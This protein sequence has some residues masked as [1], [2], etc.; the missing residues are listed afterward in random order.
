MLLDIFIGGGG[1]NHIL[2]LFIFFAIVLTN[3][4]TQQL[5]RIPLQKPLKH[6]E[7]KSP[8]TWEKR[9]R[10][11]DPKTGRQI[12]Y[13][14]KPRIEVADARAG[15][16]L[17][18]WIGYDGRE[19]V[20]G[21]QRPDCIDV[22][23]IAAVIKTTSGYQY[24]YTVK[25]LK[26]SGDYIQGFTVQNFSEDISPKK[27]PQNINNVFLGEMSLGIWG[28]K[29]NWIRFAPLPPHPKVTPGQM[30]KF[31]LLSP[32]P[33]G[34]VECRADGGNSATIGVGED[35]PPELQGLSD[36]YGAWPHGFTIGPIDELKSMSQQQR[37]AYLL[38]IL[39]ECQRQGWIAG[40]A[41]TAY[42]KSLQNG[43]LG[44][45]WARIA[46]DLKANSITTELFAIFDGLR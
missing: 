38:R 18:K 16:Y 14:P 27:R 2:I 15:K 8:S 20:M 26:T 43:D 11:I 4:S 41:S 37:I 44:S 22:I 24:E 40:S 29:G 34:L 19:K 21:Y 7:L 31:K 13:D 28:D 39:P 3:I 12:Q 32:A 45:I 30:I 23:V 33:P 36:Y 1:V 46:G 5:Q 10:V 9:F 42:Q 17:F 35:P 25:N 6:I